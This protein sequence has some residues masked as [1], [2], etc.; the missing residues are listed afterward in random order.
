MSTAVANEWGRRGL[1]DL[2]TTHVA[3][4]VAALVFLGL[5]GAK[6]HN[7][8][9]ASA[10]R[11]HSAALPLRAASLGEVV[12]DRLVD[13][14]GDH[15]ADVVRVRTGIIVNQ[16]GR[17][18]VSATMTAAGGLTATS[19]P[20]ERTLKAGAQTMAIDFRLDGARRL[21][22]GGPYKIVNAVIT[23]GLD[24]K[25]VQQR[26]VLGYTTAVSPGVAIEDV[27]TMPQPQAVPRDD[28]GDAHPNRLTWLL[29][30]DLPTA[31]RYRIE[32][33][34]VDPSG[35][36]TAG[37]E[38]VSLQLP[39]S[40]KV[41]IDFPGRAIL[42]GGSGVYTL[43]RVRMSQIGGGASF[44]TGVRGHTSALDAEVWEP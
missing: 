35:R 19:D 26:R 21:G 17:Y 9:G 20:W 31:G 32:A 43:G 14:D 39:G 41:A 8:T 29:N 11:I 2:D 36:E 10:A 28:D 42:N 13:L 44:V 7:I 37:S 25:I 27:Q 5:V 4:L 33:V 6:V 1:R 38:E 23:R 3:T 16:D 40:Q 30:P 18:Q 24:P 15:V 34:L 22:I 12:G